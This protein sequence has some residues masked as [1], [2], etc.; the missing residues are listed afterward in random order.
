MNKSTKL[1]KLIINSMLESGKIA[2]VHF[3]KKSD[4]SLRTL[5]CRRK[6]VKPVTTR[7]RK[8][9]PENIIPVWDLK[10]GAYKSFDVDTVTQINGLGCSM[11]FD[12][13][14]KATLSA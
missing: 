8:P 12:D 11:T 2:T 5:N 7:S 1:K 6:S 10:S 14:G 9:F 4:G 13:E 3:I